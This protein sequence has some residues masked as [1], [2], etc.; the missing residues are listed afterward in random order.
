MPA[1]SSVPR[2]KTTSMS[3]Q[4]GTAEAGAEVTTAAAHT[5][6]AAVTAKILRGVLLCTGLSSTWSADGWD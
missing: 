6:V 4:R 2:A 5:A 3:G 1:G